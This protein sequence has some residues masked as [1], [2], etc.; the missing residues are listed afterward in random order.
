MVPKNIEKKS[1]LKE[2]IRSFGD[3]C[4]QITFEIANHLS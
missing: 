4:F 1:I 2:V 3:G